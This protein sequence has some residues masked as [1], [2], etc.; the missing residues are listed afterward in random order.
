MPLCKLHCTSTFIF[1]ILVLLSAIT[2][3]QPHHLNQMQT[4]REAQLCP[5]KR[6]RKH[7]ELCYR[8]IISDS[9][10]KTLLFPQLIHQTKREQ[11]GHAFPSI[12]T[13]HI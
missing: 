12:D 9:S 11:F 1:A 3:L 8:A 4:D 13:E 2:A 10:N 5:D 7:G 6:I